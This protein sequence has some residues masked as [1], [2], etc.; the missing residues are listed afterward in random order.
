MIGRQVQFQQRGDGGREAQVEA[1][2]AGA[3]VAAGRPV[4]H[5]RVLAAPVDQQGRAVA[6][7]GQ[8]SGPVF[9]VRLLEQGEVKRIQRQH[10]PRSA[11]V[12]DLPV[13][14]AAQVLAVEAGRVG[15]GDQPRRRRLLHRL[16][17]GG[18]ADEVVELVQRHLQQDIRSDPLNLLR[19]PLRR[20][21]DAADGEG[22][23]VRRRVLATDD[24]QYGGDGG[25]DR[26]R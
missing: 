1:Q 14:V 4:Q 25:Q 9:K 26:Q 18:A 7:L 15:R 5:Q 12:D 19:R 16:G 17:L 10:R 3:R 2:A 23:V 22:V 8:Q 24:G 20:E 6:N 21:D 11:R 13:R